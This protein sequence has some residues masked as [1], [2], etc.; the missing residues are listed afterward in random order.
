MV[1]KKKKVLIVSY[2]FPPL[3]SMAAK[4]Y[5]Y[6]CKYMCEN[7]Y[8]PYVITAR[9]RGG[10]YL[11]VKMDLTVPIPETNIIRIGA[12]GIRYPITS[13]LPTIMIDNYRKKKKKSRIMAEESWGWLEKV[14]KEINLNKLQDID[15]IVGTFPSTG[16]LLV[17]KYIAR[18]LNIP[19]I[20]EIRDLISDYDEGYDWNEQEKRKEVFLEKCLLHG[21]DGIIA[22]TDGFKKIL[23]ER[24]PRIKIESIYNGWDDND[25][26]ILSEK[27]SNYIYYAGSLYEHRVESLLLLFGIIKNMDEE[28]EIRIRSLGPEI[29]DNRLRSEICKMGLQDRV[30]MLKPMPENVIQREQAEAY[31]NLLVSSLHEDD[32]ALMA[33]L[34]GK[35]FELMRVDS[36]IL[37]IVSNKA[38]IGNVLSITKKGI[39]TTDEKE[40]RNFILNSYVDFDGNEEVLD[41]SRKNQTKKLCHFM[42]KM[43]IEKKGCKK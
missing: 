18:Q 6:M 10:G 14:K 5:G 32:P 26:P 21:V 3:N 20:A 4:R 2:H 28:I 15:I 40:I 16:N 11:N 35:L 31:I 25:R 29:F 1:K 19:F 8:E 27:K 43:F 12:V 39:A 23:S 24:Y 36:P 9:A 17:G 41:Y 30:K 37:A 7:G 34:P 38:E 42:D 33:T 13:V 22:V